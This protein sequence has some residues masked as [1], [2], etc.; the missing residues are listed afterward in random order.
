MGGAGAGA[1]LCPCPLRW[2]WIRSTTSGRTPCT[3][4]T[5][6][7]TCPP[8]ALASC[9]LR[10]VVLTWRAGQ[11]PNAMSEL[12]VNLG[13]R[14]EDIYQVTSPSQEM[15]ACRPMPYELREP[16]FGQWEPLSP[17]GVVL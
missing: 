11:L 14:A 6:C 7:A 17:R 10:A 3:I 15:A 13:H 1:G 5:R 2:T 8:P 16:S 12:V 4:R 9:P